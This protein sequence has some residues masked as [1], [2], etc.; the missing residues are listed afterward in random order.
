M[1]LPF[2]LYDESDNQ[3]INQ[4]LEQ[5]ERF[6]KMSQRLSESIESFLIQAECSTSSMMSLCQLIKYYR[7]IRE[8]APL[9]PKEA[10]ALQIKMGVNER[11]RKEVIRFLKIENKSSRGKKFY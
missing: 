1:S 10:K 11:E 7:R 4:L 8:I 9:P 3:L 5:L 6:I 2:W